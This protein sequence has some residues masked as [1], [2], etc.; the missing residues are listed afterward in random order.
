MVPSASLEALLS[1]RDAIVERI[2][3]AMALMAEVRTIG[4]GAFTGW[5]DGQ[6]PGFPAT[7]PPGED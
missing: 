6:H 1:S 3:K 4:A 5:Y 7:A 2:E